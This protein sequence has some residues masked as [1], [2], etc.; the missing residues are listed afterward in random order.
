MT[1]RP[2]YSVSKT[3]IRC[4]EDSGRIFWN[5]IIVETTPNFPI[6]HIPHRPI[7][8]ID[9]F[10]DSIKYKTLNSV[11]GESAPFFVSW[12]TWW[13][14][15]SLAYLKLSFG[16]SIYRVWK[17]VDTPYRAMWDTAYWGFLGV[18]T[19]FDIF[20]NILLLYC[21]YG[22]LMSPGYGVL[23]ISWS[24]DHN[25]LLLYCE[26]GILM[27]PGYG[28]LG[29]P[30]YYIQR[31]VDVDTA[32][33]SKSVNGLLIRQ[34]MSSSTVTY[35]SVYTDSEL[36]RVFWGA[37][38][39][40][41][42]GVPSDDEAPLEDQPL[43]IDATPTTLS[44]GYV[45]DF[46]PDKDL[47]EDP[48]EDHT[49]YPTD[50]GDGVDE[51][52]NDDHDDDTDDKDEYP[53]EDEDDDK[54]EDEHLAL[55]DS[56]TV[57]TVDPVPPA[58][59]TKAIE[60]DESAPIPRSPQTKAC[61]AEHAA[62]PTPPLPISTPPLPLPSPLTTSPTDAGTD[63]PEA[64]MPPQKRACFT[65]LAP[66]LEVRESS[67]A[68]VVRQPGPTLEADLRQD[69]VMETGYGIIDA[70]DEIVEAML[71]VAP[72]T[73]K[74]VNQRVT[75]LATTI[76]QE[77]KEF[78]A[79]TSSED[80]SAAIE[81]Y[82]RTLE[83][84]VATLIA[85][86]LALIEQGV[87]AVL[88]E[89][90][91]DRSRNGDDDHDLGTGERRQVST[92]RECT[93]TDFLKCHPMNFKGTEWVVGLTQ[94]L[95]K[96]E[97]VFYI[98]NCTV[99]CQELALMCDRM[100]PEELDVVEKY[101]GGLPD[102]IHGSVKASKP[103]TMQEAIEF[104]TEPMDKKI[105]TIT[106]RQAENKRKFEDTSRNNQNQQ[107]SFKR[108]NVARAFTAGPSEKKPYGGSKHLCPK[109]N[110]HHDGPCAPK[111]TNCKRIGHLARD[112]KSWSATANNN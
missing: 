6:L 48:E 8:R 98:S 96:M 7:R 62:A 36:G 12:S 17:Q 59:D 103:K 43:P 21:E 35:T 11:L 84:L 29:L 75:E 111:C 66:R 67:A 9:Q 13:F 87:T 99:A 101:V 72:T 69:R 1:R 53:F 94:W 95:E 16:S 97:S 105:L 93:Y 63:I 27:S 49:D 22:V 80:R 55:V 47:E 44:L 32:Y 20:Q 77:T 57:P 104:A 107:Q 81:A 50:G 42:D 45:A 34:I 73:L 51:P 65:T 19:T 40:L 31:I 54:E 37:D 58:R 60:T 68:G 15:D 14:R 108:N 85:Q 4:T 38:E 88:A 71:E 41:S 25:I 90:D 100:F 26:Y 23:G 83:A 39:E 30:K 78:Q 52:S 56:F 18:R 86:T 24:K 112:Y 74:G 2:Q 79:W 102:M 70:W 76:R 3:S 89:R 10:P 110:Y 92:V 5:I 109:C 46:D 28:V 61:I 64:E 33:S 91:A 106:E 82:V